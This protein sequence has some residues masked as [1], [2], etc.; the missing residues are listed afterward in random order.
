MTKLN[1]IA[2]DVLI[3]DNNTKMNLFI[4]AFE[5]FNVPYQELGPGTNRGAFLID[6]YV[7][8]IG[9]DKAG[10]ADNWAEFSLGQE[11][12]PFVTK[13]Y[14]CNGLIAVSEYVTVISKEEFNNSKEEVRQILSHLADS[15]LLGD[16]GSV[17]KNFMNWGYR[18]DGSLVILDYAYIYRV[19]GDE[20]ICGALISDTE[21]VYCDGSLEYDVNFHK[22]ICPKCRRNYTFHEIR[23]KISKEYEEKEKSAIKDI[24]YKLTKPSQEINK[25]SNT[26]I[27]NEQEGDVNMSEYPYFNNNNREDDDIKYD[28]SMYEDAINFMRGNI[29]EEDNLII[30]DTDPDDSELIV[31]IVQ[32]AALPKLIGTTESD[33]KSKSNSNDTDIDVDVDSVD[34]NTEHV[35]TGMGIGFESFESDFIADMSTAFINNSATYDSDS[36]HGQNLENSLSNNDDSDVDADDLRAMLIAD[37]EDYEDIHDKYD[38]MYGDD[39]PSFQKIGKKKE[40]N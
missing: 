27:V 15:Y 20:L 8:K 11:L 3:P 21:E 2:L 30:H 25:N 1:S 5:E 16:V 34:S 23:R 28:E 22:L 12:Q 13:C 36:A 24:A 32:G 10:I 9:F 4:A 29:P 18:E 31:Q 38:A 17:T 35:S 6:G 19:I 26:T 37:A 40:F 39:S 33:N 14:E 7:F